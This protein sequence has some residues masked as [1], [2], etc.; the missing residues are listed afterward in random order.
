MVL[1]PASMGSA[2][3]ARLGQ[4]GPVRAVELP[5][6]DHR[7]AAWLVV[8]RFLAVTP[9][10]GASQLGPSVSVKLE[11]VQP[12]GPFKVRGGLPAP[13]P[14]LARA[15]ARAAGVVEEGP[16][17]GTLVVPW[18]GGGL[19]AGV[20][21][22]LEGTGVRVVGVESEAS[23]SMSTA[24]AAGGIVPIEVEPTVAGGLAGNLEAGAGSR[25]GAVSRGR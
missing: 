25:G 21:I 5:G 2:C 13:S 20:A 19:L 4:T 18:G 22:G 8:R 9:V 7:E 14:P 17:L 1:V 6:P 15:P 16:N 10:V 23:P 12:T 3:Q 11:T 24:L